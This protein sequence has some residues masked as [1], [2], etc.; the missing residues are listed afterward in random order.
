VS[1]LIAT[2]N[3]IPF[4][5]KTLLG[6]TRQTFTD[7]EVIICDDGSDADVGSLV[8]EMT[9]RFEFGLQH[10]MQEDDGFKK[11]M[12]LNKGVLKARSDYLIFLDADCIPHKSF[13]A[14]HVH[15]QKRGCFL[16]GRRVELG[17]AVTCALDDTKILSGWLERR[18]FGAL[19]DVLLKRARHLEAGVYLPRFMRSGVDK[20]EMGLLGCN[21]SCWKEDLFAINGFDEDFI[22]AGVGEDTD[23]ERRLRIIG[24][25]SKSVKHYAICYHQYHPLVS[26]REDSIELFKNL[27]AEGRSRCVMGLD[28][29]DRVS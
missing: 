19:L 17:D 25:K 22:S 27:E 8:D 28:R 5:R 2:Y 24:L 10:V 21:F 23:L 16:V 26:G 14:E 9:G 1:I 11:C 7:F 4:L 3:H 15:E 13:V 18:F 29:Y 12:I 6:L 20:G